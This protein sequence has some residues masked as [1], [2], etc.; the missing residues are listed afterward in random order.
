MNFFKL[1]IIAFVAFLAVDAIW[2]GLVAPKFYKSQIGGLMAEKPNFIA[3]G[4]FYVLFIAGLVY[5]ILTGV[6][7]KELGKVLLTGAIFGFMTYATYDLTNLATLKDWPIT[8]TIVDLI[9]GTFLS[10][11]VTLI[12]YLVYNWIW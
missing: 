4:V 8:V 2:L 3:A 7:E 9:W 11:S 12:S 5:F 1:Y 6:E 10:T